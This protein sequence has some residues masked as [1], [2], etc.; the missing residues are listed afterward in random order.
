VGSY[1]CSAVDQTLGD[2][3]LKTRSRHTLCEHISGQHLE[4]QS[5][6]AEKSRDTAFGATAT[7]DAG[8]A[9][10][11]PFES[12]LDGESDRSTSSVRAA[13]PQFIFR[14]ARIS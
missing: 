4:T 2:S 5:M 6:E 11:H 14:A 3:I 12:G 13:R 10:G 9:D 1:S 7:G 8:T